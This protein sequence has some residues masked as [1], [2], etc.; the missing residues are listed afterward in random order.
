MV[1][2]L[3]DDDENGFA[4]TDDG[5]GMMISGPRLMF[6]EETYWDEGK[7]GPE[8]EELA[9]VWCASGKNLRGWLTHPFG[10][11]S[12]RRYKWIDP[13]P[14]REFIEEMW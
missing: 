11:E 4:G 12:E 2:T 10:P 7:Y 1:W 14:R 3:I 9:K 5:A 6:I 13:V 8:P